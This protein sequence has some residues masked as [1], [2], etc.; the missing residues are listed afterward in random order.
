M[1][2][3][4][5]LGAGGVTGNA[6]ETGLLKG[7]RDAGLDLTGA[8]LIVGTSTGA[9]IG[10]QIATGASLD[11]VYRRQVERPR[12]SEERPPDLGKLVEFFTARARAAGEPGRQ[13]RRTPELLAWIGGQARACSTRISEA[14]RLE[15]I[16]SRLPAHEW[17]E[18]PLIVTAIDT[19]DGSLVA[20]RRSSGV[21]LALAVASSCA[22]PWVYPPVTINGR[23]YMDAGMRSGTNADLA[24]TH[25][26]VLVVAPMAAYDR[27]TLDEEVA[28][29]RRGGARVEVV[30][31]DV[32]AVEA[33]G[34]NPLDPARRA[35]AAEAGLA[36]AAAAAETLAGIRERLRS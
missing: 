19:A 16:K 27:E 18:R 4:L 32:S 31:P 30:V 13:T 28:D 10:A 21:P 22:V 11:D 17:P 20:W 15:V 25:E 2:Y 5:V 34:P 33:M 36:Q 24:C 23:R 9:V 29:L 14:S 1:T 6:W 35:A 3:A 7:L 26:L 12:R 8:A